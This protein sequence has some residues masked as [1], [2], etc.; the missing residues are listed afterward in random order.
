ME[1]AIAALTF[2]LIA[3]LKP[4]P[5]GIYVVSQTLQKGIRSGF[6]SSLAPLITDGPI[7]AL[8]LLLTLSIE[9]QKLAIS[10]ISIIGAIYL[11]NISYK[12]LANTKEVSF[13]SGSEESAIDGLF[14]S[15]KINLL[16]PSPYLFWLTIGGSYIVNGTRLE[17]GVFI[18]VA[19]V[20]L[21][22][23]KFIVA[24]LVLALGSRFN[25][26]AYS[27]LLKTLALP[28]IYF[29]ISL[30]Y[31]GFQQLDLTVVL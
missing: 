27:I 22:I 9:E 15:V 16:N 8:A 10:I 21:C 23:T 28:L 31:K 30:F 13:N 5:L 11:A 1:H 7:I 14:T 29:S 4:G 3:G 12:T 25:P 2:G 17:A 18:S 19:L 26:K 20:T 6:L 24:L